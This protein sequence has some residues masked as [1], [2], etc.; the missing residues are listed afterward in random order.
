MSANAPLLRRLALGATVVSILTVATG[1]AA[2]AQSP[3]LPS[4]GPRGGGPGAV[5]GPTPT[6]ADLA[7]A[8]TSP[9]QVLDLWLPENVTG[10]V[11]LVVFIHGGAFKM[12]DKS[13]EAGNVASVLE[14]GYAAASLNYRLSGEAIF[15]AAV[16]DVKAAVRWLRANAATYGLDPDRFATWGESAGGH[17]AAMIGVTGDQAT[18][19]DDP[20][21]GNADVSSAV[22]AVVDWYGPSDFLQMDAQFE[23]NMPAACGGTVQN[24]DD[25]SS[26]ESA[27]LGAA[28]Q[29]VP[30]VAT[31]ANPITY[32]ATAT[33]LPVF[34]LAAGDSDCLVPHQQVLILDEALRAA[35]GTSSVT[36]VP[37]AGHGDAAITESQTPV[38]LAMLAEVFGE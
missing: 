25:A 12:G 37:G 35:G 36:I 18:I 38:A 32:V 29:S 26:P 24:H 8:S 14:K 5:S 6:H 16:A 33:E 10:P 1:L 13:M 31:A 30:D 27:F 2:A 3:G 7:Y 9:S 22:Q 34:S 19:F 4:G 20:S 15:P 21:L 11:P 23:A 28:I 17:L